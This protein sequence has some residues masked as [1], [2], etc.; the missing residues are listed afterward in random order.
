MKALIDID[1]SHLNQ[2]E[3]NQDD[4]VDYLIKFIRE[5][6]VSYEIQS[7]SESSWEVVDLLIVFDFR[8]AINENKR[9]KVAKILLLQMESTAYILPSFLGPKFISLT[10]MLIVSWCDLKLANS[11]VLPI[12]N[13]IEI[14]NEWLDEERLIKY[15]FVGANKRPPF[16]SRP[17]KDRMKIIDYC[18]KN[19]KCFELYGKM[20]D[21]RVI[22][23]FPFGLWDF[24]IK[25]SKYLDVWK[26]L[27]SRKEDLYKNLTFGFVF[28]NSY[29][30]PNYVTEKIYDCLKYSVVPIYFGHKRPNIPA[31]IYINGRNF[32][33][34]SEL[35][36]HCN[37]LSK[38]DLNRFRM[39]GNKYYASLV[40]TSVNSDIF[41]K[42]LMQII[43]SEK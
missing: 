34:P 12:P 23:L 13:K 8:R 21:T 16:S 40:N 27:L 7:I 10:K 11:L 28:E 35:F 5:L 42:E 25:S 18:I 39:L 6:S 17:Y 9:L 29:C 38:S 14:S 36:N 43:N 41:V 31:D 4:R 3:V 33:T 32:R 15:A 22:R 30:N 2:G 1:Y 24:R 37:G 20:W 26:G 19:L